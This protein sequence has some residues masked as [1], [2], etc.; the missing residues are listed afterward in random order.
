M[1]MECYEDILALLTIDYNGSE[2]TH[3]F[4]VYA[5]PMEPRTRG[6]SEEFG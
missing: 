5:N 3:D 6:T 1:E 2:T 4:T